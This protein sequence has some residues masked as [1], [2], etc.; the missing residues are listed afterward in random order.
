MC[1]MSKVV[2][3]T[4]LDFK[5]GHLEKTRMAEGNLTRLIF[6]PEKGKTE[7]GRRI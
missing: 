3:Q 7:S 5:F 6:P 2:K 4:T 1:R